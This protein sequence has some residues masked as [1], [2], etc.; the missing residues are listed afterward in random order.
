VLTATRQAVTE[1]LK[2]KIWEEIA[3]ILQEELQK[4][5]YNLLSE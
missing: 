1:E 4:S 3:F 5:V 2:A